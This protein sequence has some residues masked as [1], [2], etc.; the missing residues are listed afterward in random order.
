MVQGP[1]S[2][3]TPH[4]DQGRG[5]KGRTRR[6]GLRTK[7][8]GNESALAMRLP[9]RFGFRLMSTVRLFDGVG[10]RDI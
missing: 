7:L 6:Y 8:H 10:L 4:R 5:T 1:L 9:T 2:S 3:A